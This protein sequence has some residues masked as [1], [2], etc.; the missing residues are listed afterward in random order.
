MFFGLQCGVTLQTFAGAG[1]RLRRWTV[2]SVAM[3]A[4]GGSLAGWSQDGGWIPVNKILWSASFVL[5]TTA[6][7]YALLAAC[8]AATDVWR[9]RSGG[10][11]G[12][13]SGA[14]FRWAGMNSIVLY[15]GHMLLHQAMPFKWR[16]GEMNEHLVLLLA[17]GWT[18]GLW[19][20]VAWWMY[21]RQWFVSV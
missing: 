1:Q 18:A 15:V 19:V 7:A 8:Y 2:W 13:W 4:V 12:G 16:L 21:R 17:N 3:A 6:L 5:V 14:P 20:A 10:G 9:Q 11:R